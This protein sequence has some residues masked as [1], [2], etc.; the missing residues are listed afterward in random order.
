V[1]VTYRLTADDD[2]AVAGGGYGLTGM[3]DRV[4]AHGGHFDA[5]PATGGGWRVH[6]V[7][8]AR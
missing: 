5:G 1:E 6:A 7:L 8:P 4:L 3:R 2:A